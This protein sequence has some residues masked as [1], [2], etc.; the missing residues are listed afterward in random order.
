MKLAIG[1]EVRG[2]FSPAISETFVLV[3]YSPPKSP[4]PT[5]PTKDDPP[6]TRDHTQPLP[7]PSYGNERYENTILLRYKTFAKKRLGK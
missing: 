4:N 7:S 2:F 6:K 1:G 5:A 3:L